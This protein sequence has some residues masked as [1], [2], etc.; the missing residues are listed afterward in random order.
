[1]ALED[2][3]RK[4]KQDAD[5]EAAAILA[6]ARSRHDQIL[7][8][9]RA[10]AEAAAERIRSAGVIAAEEA[11]RRELATASVEIRRLVLSAKQQVL[12]QVFAAALARLADLEEEPYRQLL[13]DLALRAT[14]SGKEQVLVS[15]RDRARLDDSWLAQVNSRLKERGLPA[16]LKFADQTR[17]LQ[18]GLILKAGDIETNC[19][20]ERTLALLQDSIEPEIA[21]MLFAEQ[22]EGAGQ[23]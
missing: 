3:L 14:A 9:G 1:M 4:I 11:R 2:I 23:A 16:E 8:E 13:G 5:D 21:A 22:K 12:E 19:S 17:D 10:R 6:E 15:P 20:F 7:A 18:G